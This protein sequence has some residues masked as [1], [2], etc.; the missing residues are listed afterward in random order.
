MRRATALRYVLLAYGAAS[1]LVLLTTPGAVACP[2]CDGG[3]GGVNE[4]R[5]ELFGPEFWPNLLAAAAPFGVVLGVVVVV[6]R[7]SRPP[8]GAVPDRGEE[9]DA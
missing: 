8:R 6:L 7:G 3:P 1:V 2:F 5:R 4:V 9:A